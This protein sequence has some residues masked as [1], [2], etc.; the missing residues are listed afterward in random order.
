MTNTFIWSDLSTFDIHKA[1]RF[2]QH[3]F[4]WEYHS[5]ADGYE[6]CTIGQ[7]TIAAMYP[8]PFI[9]YVERKRNPVTYWAIIMTWLSLSILLLLG[10]ITAT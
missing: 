6:L 8:M 7:Q 5:I 4:G 9:E 1:K 2:Y 3:C 10:L